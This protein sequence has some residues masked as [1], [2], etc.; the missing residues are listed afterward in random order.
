VPLPYTL[1]EGLAGFGRTRFAALTSTTALVVALVL[2][3]LVGLLAWQ[4]QRV[5][6][7]VQQRVGEVQVY[8]EPADTAAVGRLQRRLAALPGVGEVTFVSQAEA[9][10]EFREAFGEEASLFD[11]ETFLPASFRVRFQGAYASP[12]SLA[13][14]QDAVARWPRVDEVVYERTLVERVT[15]NVRL[16]SLVGLAVGALVVLAALLLVGNTVRL[17]IYARRLLIRT[18]KLVGATDG[19]IRRPFLV[20]GLVQGLVAGAVAAV[21]VGVLYAGAGR[22]VEGLAVAGW[23]GGSAVVPLGALVVLGAALGLLAS[24]VAVRTFIRQVRLS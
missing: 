14:V 24:W 21:L 17:S 8:L 6:E 1:R 16:Y 7:A 10:R 23:P 9:A 15:R 20:E 13:A 12:D 18:M 19:F 2:I 3:G 22:L 4:G 11:A 5:A